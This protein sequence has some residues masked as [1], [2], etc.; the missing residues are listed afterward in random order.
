[1]ISVLL[2]NY[3]EK[4]MLHTCTHTLTKTHIQ[5]DND[6]TNEAKG[7][8]VILKKDCHKV[9]CIILEIFL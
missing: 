9:P 4:K 6:K 1:M 2:S 7:K 5:T 3:F 8:G